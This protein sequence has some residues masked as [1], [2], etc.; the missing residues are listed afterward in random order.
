MSGVGHGNTPNAELAR[1]GDEPFGTGMRPKRNDL[2]LV[3]ML[4]AYIERLRSN[5]TGAPENRHAKTVG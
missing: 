5:R 1:L 4:S 3:G 2:E